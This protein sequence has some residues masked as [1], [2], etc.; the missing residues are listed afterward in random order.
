MAT[1]AELLQASAN[2]VLNAKIRVGVFI[3][4]EAVR[5]E[6]PATTNHANRMKWAK[7]VFSDPDEAAKKMIWAVLAQNQAQTLAVILNATDAQVQ[8]A[9]NAAIDV[10]ADGV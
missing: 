6:A 7:A 5:T 9:I 2:D 4:A 8:V 3:G 10:F 1:Y